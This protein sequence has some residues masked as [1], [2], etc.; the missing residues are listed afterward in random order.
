MQ[1][2][3]V[4]LIFDHQVCH[5]LPHHTGLSWG[6]EG[7]MASE[8]G[9]EIAAEML[10]KQSTCSTWNEGSQCTQTGK[11]VLQPCKAAFS[12]V[13]TLLVSVL[14]HIIAF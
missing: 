7:E 12:E 8:R 2:S 13:S 6:T 5:P 9:M 1:W 11:W 4:S 10:Q 3:E 14:G